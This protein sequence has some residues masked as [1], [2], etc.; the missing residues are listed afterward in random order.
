MARKAGRLGRKPPTVAA[1]RKRAQKYRAEVRVFCRMLG[2]YDAA[3]LT[4]NTQGAVA[5]PG[6]KTSRKRPTFNTMSWGCAR[7]LDLLDH[8][9]EK[10]ESNGHP[11]DLFYGAV[12]FFVSAAHF[13]GARTKMTENQRLYFRA[14]WAAHLGRRGGAKRRREAAETWQPHALELAIAARE[15]DAHLTQSAVA[16]S[17]EGGWRLHIP[18]PGH[19]TLQR[20]VATCEKDGTLPRRR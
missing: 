2:E 8:L 4:P 6:I 3:K 5:L 12:R 20:F 9:A 17:I 10:L 15:R 16:D 19:G 1:L 13:I 18:C 14:A 11:T 7:N